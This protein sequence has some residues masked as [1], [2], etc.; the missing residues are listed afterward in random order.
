MEQRTRAVITT[1]SPDKIAA[2]Q[3]KQRAETRQQLDT[4]IQHSEDVIAEVS[5]ALQL[6]PLTITLDRT[7]LSVS[8]KEL[9]GSKGIA[10]LPMDDVNNVTAEVGI[11]IGHIKIDKKVLNEEGVL[12][13]GPFWRKDALK[14]ATTAQ[15]FVMARK[16]DIEMDTLPTGELGD[17]LKELGK[18][19]GVD[20]TGV[21]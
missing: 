11:L 4:A 18:D 5:T 16:H 3:A 21:D 17:K 12:K 14:F 7:K 9:I 1:E 2:E 6:L 8:K 20:Y 15:G 19:E 13:F 10:S